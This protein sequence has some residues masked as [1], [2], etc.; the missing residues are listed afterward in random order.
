MGL[1]NS[2]NTKKSELVLLGGGLNAGNRKKAEWWSSAFTPV[3]VLHS[4]FRDKTR[5]S[6]EIP[7]SLFWG[8]IDFYLM[9][10]GFFT[11]VVQYF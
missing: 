2:D 11:L 8:L 5:G 6:Q 1:L 3:M 10:L 4:L 9:K 7:M